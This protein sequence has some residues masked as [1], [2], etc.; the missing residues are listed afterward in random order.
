VVSPV[1]LEAVKQETANRKEGGF[2][3]FFKILQLLVLNAKTNDNSNN[4]L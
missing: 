4:P 3:V 2:F 1:L